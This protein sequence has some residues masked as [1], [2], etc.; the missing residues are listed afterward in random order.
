MK[1]LLAIFLMVFLF[2]SCEGPMALRDETGKMA[3]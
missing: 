2:A 3:V 1:N